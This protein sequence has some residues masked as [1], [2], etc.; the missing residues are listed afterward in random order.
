MR[1]DLYIYIFY[2]TVRSKHIWQRP[3]VVGYL[4]REMER[5]RERLIGSD[6]VALPLTLFLYSG[7]SYFPLSDTHTH[8][9]INRWLLT[10]ELRFLVA[11]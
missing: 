10:S 6:V 1:G 9:H 11:A 2:L 4:L 7:A 5:D 3:P 8:T